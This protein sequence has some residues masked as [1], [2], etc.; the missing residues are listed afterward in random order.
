M[1]NDIST[2]DMMSAPVIEGAL[3]VL[4]L[5]IL[6]QMAFYARIVD[7][8]QAEF[9]TYLRNLVRTA[10]PRETGDRVAMTIGG[11]ELKRVPQDNQ[12]FSRRKSLAVEA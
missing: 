3:L 6:A 4:L 7:R 11:I 10:A 2:L 8:Y 9:V 1:N 5:I 12:R